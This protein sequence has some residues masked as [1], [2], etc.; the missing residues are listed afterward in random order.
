MTIPPRGLVSAER[1]ED[2]AAAGAAGEGAG[3]K[4]IVK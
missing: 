3:L 4:E 2:G 1:R